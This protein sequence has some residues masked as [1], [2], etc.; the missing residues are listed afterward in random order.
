MQIQPMMQVNESCI[1]GLL[2][3]VYESGNPL[4]KKSEM[5][6]RWIKTFFN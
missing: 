2:A 6:Y 1:E 4:L 3:N 5:Y